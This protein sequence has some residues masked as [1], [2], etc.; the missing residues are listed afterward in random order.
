MAQPIAIN[1]P[2]VATPARASHSHGQIGARARQLGPGSAARFE[3]LIE[4]KTPLFTSL[5]LATHLV[6]T[7]RLLVQDAHL[8]VKKRRLNES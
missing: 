5:F 3:V 7:N 6:G 4:S 8:S 1:H 2:T